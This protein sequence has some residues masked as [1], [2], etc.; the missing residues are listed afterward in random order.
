[1]SKSFTHKASHKGG[2]TRMNFSDKNSRGFT[3]IELL[4]V[5]AIIGI[6][7]S[8]VLASLNSA[9]TKARDARRV[10]DI[11]QVQIALELYFDSN[12]KYPTD[13]AQLVISGGAGGASLA[14]LPSDPSGDAIN[15][16][17]GYKYAINNATTP[18]GYHLGA[19]LEQSATQTTLDDGDR[20]L[21]SSAAGTAPL[22]WP[23]SVSTSVPFAGNTDATAVVYDISNL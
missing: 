11:K 18:T 4:V 3:L 10:A 22:S 1:M 9:R 23:T 17:N 21:N 12:A 19:V 5:I 6:L 20:D 14:S 7:S 2:F 16:G 8:V 13:L 15:T